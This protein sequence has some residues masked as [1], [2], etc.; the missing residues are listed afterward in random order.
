[1]RPFFI[2]LTGISGAGKST[3]ADHLQAQGGVRRFRFDSYYK[4][5]A[6]CPKLESGLPNWDLPESLY[7]N[8]VHNDLLDL[9]EGNSIFLPIY[10]RGKN[11]R[12][13]SVLYNPAPVIFIEGLHIFSDENIR[14]LLDL[15]LWL[16][17]PE[18]VALQRRLKRQP[19]YNIDYHW[20]V[21]VPAHREYVLP[22]KKYAHIIIDG[23]SSIIDVTNSVD[24]AVHNFLGVTA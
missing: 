22:L 11:S 3:I 23:R 9:K 2:G 6:D 5:E 7:L 13:G 10:N 19:N 24:T 8:E 18:E 15:R 21:A 12:T 14:N 20:S 17:V 4:T 1:M 16:D